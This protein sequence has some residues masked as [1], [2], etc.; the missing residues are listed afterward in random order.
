MQIS[1]RGCN[2][3]NEQSYGFES[4]RNRFAM[5]E[6]PCIPSLNSIGSREHGFRTPPLE[7]KISEAVTKTRFFIEFS[8]N[9]AIKSDR[10]RSAVLEIACIPSLN[11]I[12]SRKLGFL[13]NFSNPPPSRQISEAV[14]SF[15]YY[16]RHIR[17]YDNEIDIGGRC[18]ELELIF[19]LL[20]KSGC[21]RRCFGC[22]CI[23]EDGGSLI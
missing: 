6:I 2:L 21:K 15:P 20:G 19:G 4:D 16:F 12:G 17:S 3:V 22:A 18:N 8:N 10:N 5:L 13:S 9:Q 1:V 7:K 14:R 23:L 11:S